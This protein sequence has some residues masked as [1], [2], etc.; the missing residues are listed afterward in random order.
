MRRTKMRWKLCGEQ[1]CL[2]PASKE[3]RAFG[4]AVAVLLGLTLGAPAG[5]QIEVREQPPAFRKAEDGEVIPVIVVA[6][7]ARLRQRP[8]KTSEIERRAEFLDAY[9]LLDTA[10]EAGEH[11][12]LAGAMT[13]GWQ[14]VGE[15]VGW[16]HGD[17]VLVERQ[18]IKEK[19]GIYL[20]GLVVNQWRG[21][22]E[23]LEIEGADLLRGP[24]RDA[25]G[26]PYEKTAEI[27][28]FSF[29]FIYAGQESR[30]G[31]KYYLLGES[32]ILRNV[33]RPG[34][35]LVGWV[36]AR[37][38]EEWSTRQAIQ[39]DKQ[40]LEQRVDLAE[41]AAETEGVKIFATEAEVIADL[42]G[43]ATIAGEPP[44]PVAVEDT[45]VRRWQHNWPR[46]PL[47]EV[48]ANREIPA[49]G[50]L[51]H[52]GF[53]GDQIYVSGRTGIPREEIAENQEKVDELR[54]D[55]D[56][57]DLLFVI[58]STGSMRNYFQSAAEAVGRIAEQVRSELP[59]GGGGPEIRYSVVFFRDY[60]DED[61]KPNP[62]DTYL[63]KRLPFTG[64]P[65]AV[66]K[67]L[68]DEKTM[69]CNGCG[70]DEP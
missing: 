4:R 14:S 56:N 70:G 37:R 48:K 49:A 47:F 44:R 16:L 5:A 67:F 60:V 15:I 42:R 34:E 68:R 7:G 46:F 55:L 58:D 2:G 51:Y 64:N 65:S 27:G 36:D 22:S 61:G 23:G 18:A 63:T 57:I 45:R 32:P 3:G 21:V 53:M 66:A 31:Q 25:S 52:V 62:E 20:K 24:G 6:D 30:P 50:P 17:D 11:Y 8:S 38:V 29:Y 39:F 12:Y 26:D 10:E 40:T 59:L 35:T 54:Q 33:T 9:F 19:N 69:L 41:T 43:G 28:L 13:A 1:N